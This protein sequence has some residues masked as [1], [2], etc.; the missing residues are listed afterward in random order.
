MAQY[1]QQTQIGQVGDGIIEAVELAAWVYCRRTRTTNSALTPPKDELDRNAPEQPSTAAKGVCTGATPQIVARALR[2]AADKGSVSRAPTFAGALNKGGDLRLALQQ[3][4][5]RLLCRLGPGSGCGCR[6][7]CTAREV[8]SRRFLGLRQR[9]NDL[10]IRHREGIL[11]Q[12]VQPSLAPIGA[13]QRLGDAVQPPR[14]R[15]AA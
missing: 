2:S 1:G 10:L 14:E 13:A 15:R 4:A 8:R 9:L 5:F 11:G 6:M 3:M 12:L 7:G